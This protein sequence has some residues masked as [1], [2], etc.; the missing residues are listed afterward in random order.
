MNLLEIFDG[1]V[2]VDEAYG[3]FCGHSLVNRVTQHPNGMVL[4][5]FSKAFGLAGLRIGYLI[6]NKDLVEQIYKVKPPYNVN[7]FSQRAAQLV[8]ENIDVFRG[9]ISTVIEERERLYDKLC[10]LEQVQAYPSKANFILIKV[11]DG[12]RAYQKLVEEGILVRNFPGHADLKDHLRVTVGTR[13]DND[14]FIQKL[15]LVLGGV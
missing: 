4:K 15:K 3:E 5:T 12:E 2:A 11:P 1:V 10:C 8:L 14:I 7:S 9:R 6:G 13:E